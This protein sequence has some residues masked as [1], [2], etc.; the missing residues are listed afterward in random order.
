MYDYS[1]KSGYDYGN[2]ANERVNYKLSKAESL[3]D[4]PDAFR[5]GGDAFGRP[6]TGGTN[7]S[8]TSWKVR[9]FP[10]K[11]AANTYN[12]FTFLVS[13]TALTSTRVEKTM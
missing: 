8:K 5:F 12:D 6:Q 11:L 10:E 3:L 2:T 9:S 1:K 13:L 7:M 4:E